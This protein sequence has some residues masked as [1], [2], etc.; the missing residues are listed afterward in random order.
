MCKV[1]SNFLEPFVMSSSKLVL[2]DDDIYGESLV[3]G[4]RNILWHD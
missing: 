2:G 1:G 3:L 4:M